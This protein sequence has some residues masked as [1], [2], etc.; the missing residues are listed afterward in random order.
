MVCDS[1]SQ[2]TGDFFTTE[3]AAK[4]AQGAYPVGCDYHV[5]PVTMTIEVHG[6]PPEPWFHKARS[7]DAR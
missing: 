2:P 1:M 6:S 4:Q 3:E 7:A 5:R